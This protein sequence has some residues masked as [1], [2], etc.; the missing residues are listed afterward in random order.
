YTIH[1]NNVT[2]DSH[3]RPAGVIRLDLKPDVEP[4]KL[5]QRFLE[6]FV[7]ELSYTRSPDGRHYEFHIRST[8]ESS[9]RERAVGQARE[10]INRR[11]DELGLREAAVSTRDED[12]VIEVPGEDEKSS[13]NIR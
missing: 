13:A 4:T 6:R 3:R 5:D 2:L 9:I 10:I 1:R 11:V 7:S 12:I 8:V